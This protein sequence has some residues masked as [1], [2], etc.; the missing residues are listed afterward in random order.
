MNLVIA[1]ADFGA[2]PAGQL[3]HC[4]PGLFLCAL[5]DRCSGKTRTMSK[6]LKNK[7]EIIGVL[8]QGGMGCVYKVADRSSG[9]KVFA[10]KELKPAKAA[11]P[12]AEEALTLFRTEARILMRLKHPNLPRVHDYFSHQGAHYIVMEYIRGRT[13]EQLLAARGGRPVSERLALS[14]ALQICR[15]MHFLSVQKP[16]PIVFRDLKPANIMIDHLGRVKL[17]DFGIA[18]FFREDKEEDTYV[19]GTP[20][21]AAPEQYGT[22]Q[23]DVRSDLFSLGAT[24]F[25][26]LT[27]RKPPESPLGFP[28]PRSLNPKLG[29]AVAAIISKAV[30]FDREKRFQSAFEMK[31]AIQTVLLDLAATAKGK[32]KVIRAV[33]GKTIT[34]PWRS[35]PSWVSV[36]VMSLGCSGTTGTL[37]SDDRWIKPKPAS[38]GPDEVRLLFRVEGRLL[39]PGREYRPQITVKTVAG[40]VR[41]QL[42]F[43]KSRPWMV[44]TALTIGVVAIAL[45]AV[46]KLME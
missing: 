36:P 7:Y 23:T 2:R 4:T 13:L 9:Y 8:G 17:I 42:V 43:K 37:S 31:A 29:K 11:S 16:R 46:L 1:N 19:Y 26:C 6:L 45:L 21:Y 34:L 44:I 35:R 32:G 10:A 38:F 14:W 27:G 28:D 39:A 18:R 33:P 25:H 30:E 41:P 12:K 15:A 3:E 20:G 24:L 22:G 40:V 5:C